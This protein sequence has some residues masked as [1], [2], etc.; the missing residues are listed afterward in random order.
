[1]TFNSGN[2][3]C[4]CY[5][6]DMAACNI[7]SVAQR[8]TWDFEPIVSSFDGLFIDTSKSL[9]NNNL[10]YSGRVCPQIKWKGGAGDASHCL[11]K[12][13]ENAD[14][15]YSDCGRNFVTFNAGGGC[16]CYPPDQE[17]CTRSESVKQ[18]G[19]QTYELEV[20]PAYN[21]PTTSSPSTSPIPSTI[22]STMPSGSPIITTSSPS[23][24]FPSA[25]PSTVPSGSP[26]ITSPIPSAIPSTV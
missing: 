24:S 10:P 21:A 6:T 9:S 11:Q 20:D 25:I 14:G 19:R 12:I 26:I 4:A 8:L 16:A 13:M 23:T 3:G 1:M 7:D 2:F 18:S 22:P 17:T 5:P 15:S